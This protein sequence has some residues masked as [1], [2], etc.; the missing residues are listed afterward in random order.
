MVSEVQNYKYKMNVLRGPRQMKINNMG[1]FSCH[2]S[3]S[4]RSASPNFGL[5]PELGV[6]LVCG[7]SKKTQQ[8][9][10]P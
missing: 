10:N 5:R 4:F 2:F 8:K 1:I 3:S 9:T 6:R 7:L